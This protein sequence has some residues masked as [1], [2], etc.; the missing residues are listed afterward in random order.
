MRSRTSWTK[1]VREEDPFMR[2]TRSGGV[3][4]LKRWSF[5]LLLKKPRELWNRK[6]TRFLGLNWSL[7]K[8]GR[9]LKEELLKRR[10]SLVTPRRISAE[11]L[12][13]CKEPWS[14]KAKENLRH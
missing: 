2:L 9:K 14:K 7:L 3:L 12:I 8:S 1:L 6:R 11:L 5:K 13:L 4:R 10:K